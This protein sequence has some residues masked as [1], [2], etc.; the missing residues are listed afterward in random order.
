MGEF[1]WWSKTR[2]LRSTDQFIAD[3]RAELVRRKELAAHL[4]D[5]AFGA[6][7]EAFSVV[8]KTPINGADL[9]AIIVAA[10]ERG[11]ENPA[12]KMAKLR[13]AEHYAMEH[14]ALEY[15]R[16]HIDPKLSAQKAANQLIQVVP[17]SHKKLAAIVS[18]ERKIL[19][20]L[21]KQELNRKP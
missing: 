20:P 10:M 17:L 5:C 13:H 4:V 18:R 19:S 14:E 11:A 2:G 15:W 12:A 16:T 21:R 3:Y 1:H 6:G 9:L 8:A 7:A